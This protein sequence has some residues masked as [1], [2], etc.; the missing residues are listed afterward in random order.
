MVLQ[1]CR[2]HS[3]RYMSASRFSQPLG[4]LLDRLPSVTVTDFR[5]WREAAAYYAA[6][7]DAK[8]VGWLPAA[9]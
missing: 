1:V 7:G 5:V 4:A 2:A 3:M 8:R 9:S 6:V